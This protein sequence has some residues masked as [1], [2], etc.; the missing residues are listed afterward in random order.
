MPRNRFNQYVKNENKIILAVVSG[1]GGLQSGP[2]M[3]TELQQAHR[4][5]LNALA[6]KGLCGLIHPIGPG[7]IPPRDAGLLNLLGYDPGRTA[8]PTPFFKHYGLRACAFTDDPLYAK[9]A[10]ELGFAI[11][12]ADHVAA[13][14]ERLAALFDKYDFFL[15]HYSDVEQQ[16]M[17]GDYYEKV[18]AIE[19]FDPLIP[20]LL[21]L[22]PATLAVTG[23]H[24]FPTILRSA[25]WHPVPL[26]I[27]APY[28]RFDAVQTFD[29][30]ACLAG[31]LGILSG[32]DL[33]PL[34]LANA[35]KCR[36]DSPKTARG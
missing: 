11:Q 5:H 20:A 14:P 17:T 28:C 1:L 18:K 7:I 19:A 29:E 27:S 36:L 16:A 9:I 2:N 15:L 12:P 31:G 35:G 25:S 22:R 10:R 33:M 34:L 32:R 24:S 4:P 21:P 23:D 8:E 26:V 13:L 6:R 3:L 30:I